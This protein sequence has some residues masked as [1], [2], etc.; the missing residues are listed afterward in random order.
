MSRRSAL[1]APPQERRQAE[2]LASGSAGGVTP[3]R[4]SRPLISRPLWIALLILPMIALGIALWQSDGVLEWQARRADRKQITEMA[5]NMPGSAIVQYHYGRRLMESGDLSGAVAALTS[6]HRADPSAGRVVALLSDLLSRQARFAE[7]GALIQGFTRQH[8][9]DAEA[10][11]ALGIYYYRVFAHPQ[12]AAAFQSALRLNPRDVRAWWGLAEAQMRLG[13][14]AEA[15]NSYTQ[16]LALRPGEA[17]TLLHRAQAQLA[18]NNVTAAEQD[19]RAVL[20]MTPENAEARY[21]LGE[22]L[23][24]HR[25]TQAARREAEALLKPLLAANP[26]VIEAG[27]ELSRV[28]TAEDRWPE[29]E[30]LLRAF[31]EARPHDPEGFYLYA[32]VLRHQGKPTAAVMARY[33]AVKADEEKRRNLLLR[34]QSEPRNVQ[35][36]LEQARFLAQ[37]GELAFA[38]LSYERVLHYDPTNAEARQALASLRGRFQGGDAH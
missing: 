25:F 37:H 20:R 1:S 8:P 24:R 3:A 35:A 22:L 11:C 33:Q 12:A 19:M 29:A 21:A 23:A 4:I 18:Q 32:R 26:P 16:A 2:L 7:A 36:R 10:Q 15:V 38:L 34:V 13:N 14:A 27:R 28:Y 5:R 9:Q 6:A 31:T 30:A 17:Q